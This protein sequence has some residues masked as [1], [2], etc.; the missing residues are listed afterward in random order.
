M[1]LTMKYEDWQNKYKK[2][3][4]EYKKA[5]EDTE[6]FK[7]RLHEKQGRYIQR[8]QEYR[9]VIKKLEKKIQDNS[10]QPLVVHEEKNEDQLLLDGIDVHDKEH[11]KLIEK[12]QKI[13]QANQELFD[14]NTK[15]STNIKDINTKL[16]DIVRE[17][18]TAQE[19]IKQMLQKEKAE[20]LHE[21]DEKIDQ[22][23]KQI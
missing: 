14:G 7:S 12:N 22:F 9:E 16:E 15:I 2:V 6:E 11:A 3:V 4:E 20:I 13:Q 5:K 8:E 17:L 23:K 18:D 10:C 19:G 1:N 21:F